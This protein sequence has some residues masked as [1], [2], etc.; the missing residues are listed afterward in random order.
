MRAIFATVDTGATALDCR[1][2][3]LKLAGAVGAHLARVTLIAGDLIAG[4][5]CA[6]VVGIDTWV[7]A[8]P[9]ALDQVLHT[10][11]FTLPS[12]IANF[13][14]AARLA[15]E[16]GGCVAV[17]RCSTVRAIDVG[18][19]ANTIAQDVGGIAIR[20][21]LSRGT[22]RTL[23]ALLSGVV[24]R[25]II[26]GTAMVRVRLRVD[27]DPVAF[28]RARAALVDTRTRGTHLLLRAGLAAIVSLAVSARSAVFGVR[29]RGYAAVVA[30]YETLGAVQCALPLTV[31]YLIAGALR[32][33]RR[34]RAGCRCSAVFSV[35]TGID[36]LV[37]ADDPWMTAGRS[38]AADAGATDRPHVVAAN[39]K[40]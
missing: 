2:K 36:T 11:Q 32:S 38:V 12:P 26:A 40:A 33:L 28:N 9:V 23:A 30:F 10:V 6:T 35:A 3:T 20:F 1:S 31:A 16:A 19:D 27:A 25:A 5:R 24:A 13:I 17:S 14:C 15:R 21:A 18:V 34:A 37:V 29:F 4:F 22:D 39:Y 8:L 7:D